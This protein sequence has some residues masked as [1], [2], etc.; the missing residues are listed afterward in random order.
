MKNLYPVAFSL[1]LWLSPGGG[2]AMAQVNYVRTWTAI[3][4][5]ADPNA[6]VSRP[7]TD[8][9]QITQYYDGLGRPIQTVAK[10]GSLE[11]LSGN[12]YDL[13]SLMDYDGFGRESAVYLPYVATSSDGSYKSDAY[14]AQ[15]GY[16]NNGVNP[17]AGQGE[18]GSNAHSLIT[19]E[20]SP[21]DRSALTMA[22]GNSWVGAGRGVASGYYI[23]TSVDDVKMFNVSDNGVGNWGAY[24]MTGAYPAGTL[25][26]TVTTDENGGQVVEFK[27][28]GGAVILKKVRFTAAADNGSGSGYTGWFC[29]YYIYDNYRNLRCVIQPSGV[30]TMAGNGWSFTPTILAEQC[31]RYEYDVRNRM[32]MKQVPGA[33]ALYMVYNVKDQLV[34]TQDANMRGS[35]WMVMVYD[36]LDRVVKTGLLN[37]ANGLATELNNAFNST[38]YP[39]TASGFEM[40]TQTHYDDYGGVPVISGIT[41]TY[42]S[43]WNSYFSTANNN[44]FPYPQAPAQNTAVVKG[45]AAWTQVEVLG[46]GGTQYITTSNIYDDKGRVIQMQ[47]QNYSGG[48]DVVTTQYSWAGEPLATV[49]KLQKN[50]TGA[51]TTVTVSRMSYDA[52]HRLTATTM[53]VQ[54]SL[55]N[56]NAMTGVI[57]V[58]GMQYDALGQL[59]E[60][61]LGNTKSGGSY[62]SN[63][64]E[65]LSYEYNIRGWLLG[66]NRAYVHDLSTADAV[67]GEGFTTPP[68]YSAG[69]YFGFELGYD[70]GPT[71]GGSSW[72]SSANYNGNITGMIWKS[73]YDGQ[74]RKYDFSYDAAN[75]LTAADFTQYYSGSFN[76][77]SG[78]NYTVNSLSYD[79]N[80]NILSMNQ[81]GLLTPTATSSSLVDQLSYSYISG[82]NKLQSVT[83][84]ANNYSS[85]LGDFK[86][87]PTTKTSTDYA[88]DSN[89]NLTQDLNKSI[90]AGGIT[91]NILNLPQTITVTGKGTITY[92][93][94][95]G[96]VKWRKQTVEGS[97]TTTT[98]YSEG[99]VYQND[100]LQFINHEEGRIRLNSGRNGYVFDYYLKDH[101]GN[102]RMTITD[103]NTQSTPVVDATSYYPGG[104][105]MAGI[106]GKGT[107]GIPENK[108]KYNGKELQHGE[109]SDG[110]GLEE[111]DFGARMQD[112]QLDRWWG[113]DPL[114]NKNKRWS[115]Y[116]YANNN[117]IRFI[118]PDGMDVTET[119][120]GTTYTGIDAQNVFRQLKS[121]F[122]TGNQNAGNGG[123]GDDKGKKKASDDGSGQGKKGDRGIDEEKNK[124][125]EKQYPKKKDKFEDHHVDPQYLGHPKNGPTVTIPAP[126]HQGITNEW[127][128]EW[129]YGQDGVPTSEQYE[130]IKKRVYEK[131]PIPQPK[132]NTSEVV[133]DV[134]KGATIGVGIYVL[135][136][137]VVAAVTWE[138]LGCGAALTP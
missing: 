138:C 26:K 63:P 10:Q 132:V 7:P 15:P 23:N 127:R 50:G 28:V 131:Y 85:T 66:V 93:Y 30:Q 126:Y 79:A 130:D 80:G 100:T 17:V 57:N 67:L 78:V 33:G 51:Q 136:K 19:Y 102:T 122:S 5:A 44:N 91:Y 119:A 76:S 31:F 112:P 97:K 81:Y 123:G 90:P 107:G 89:G 110:G 115:P 20:R 74:I 104:L 58:S 95:A 84:G 82:T 118:D 55:V 64:L 125:L 2:T 75:R 101:L 135:Y 121:Q 14:T 83:D 12:N 35:K 8:V 70:K 86:Y 59:K 25:Y 38:S 37:D 4:P 92:T 52:L 22:A 111:Y 60:K 73:V 68:S 36:T 72:T 54:N 1:W 39:S 43:T 87:N 41:A 18:S 21:L 49:Q 3:A 40:L 109:F 24:T 65:T 53:Q 9:R 103:D 137:I 94:D 113:I 6:M 56:S 108:Y 16:Y 105:A 47:Q 124:E 32:V 88:Y 48:I 29:T 120:E 69:N 96:G 98:L 11:S 45:L 116:T 99:V 42:Q 129:P 117:P 106:S 71:T 114:A 62:T 128:K 134:G 133:K 13:V 46:S 77:G 34:M 61:N 27:D